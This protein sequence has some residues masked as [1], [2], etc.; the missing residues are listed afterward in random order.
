VYISNNKLGSVLKNEEIA[1]GIKI[2]MRTFAFSLYFHA[3]HVR[4]KMRNQSFHV[5]PLKSTKI[6][7]KND[8]L[9]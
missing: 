4:W 6:I 8:F 1:N 5:I 2:D 3:F 9:P 7:E